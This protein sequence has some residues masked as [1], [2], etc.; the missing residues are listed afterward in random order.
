MVGIMDYARRKH[1]ASELIDD[2]HRSLGDVPLSIVA[3]EDHI[4]SLAA[5]PLFPCEHVADR[6][7]KTAISTW[8]LNLYVATG[9]GIA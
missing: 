1:L 3:S 5:T 7:R 8:D 9:R 6:T 2:L 4:V